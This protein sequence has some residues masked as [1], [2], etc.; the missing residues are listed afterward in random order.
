MADVF[1]AGVQPGGLNTSQEIKILL[2]Y[3]LATVNQPM[4]RDEV[5]DII[6][7]DGMANYFDTEDAIE[8]LLRLQH[9]VMDDARNIATT[10]TGKQIGESLSMRVPYMLRERSVKAALK[11]LKRRE[12]E[13]DNKVEIRRLE[14]GGCQVICTVFD[15]QKPLLSV[16]LRVADEYQAEQIKENFLADP[17]FLYRSNLAVLTGDASLRRA[18]TQLI[19]KL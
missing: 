1:S 12:V 11:L 15:Q 4:A 14:D 5:T 9:L 16:A 2:C 6:V 13:R 18:G 3:M 7:A 10:V 8:E 17:S 19:I